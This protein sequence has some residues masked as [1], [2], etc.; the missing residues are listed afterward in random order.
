MIF[1]GMHYLGLFISA[2]SM[3]GLQF[4]ER[5]LVE[6]MLPLMDHTFKWSGKMIAVRFFFPF[7]AP[8]IIDE[9]IQ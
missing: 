7:H 8:L 5:K 3:L 6:Q 4:I 2:L 1:L 9:N